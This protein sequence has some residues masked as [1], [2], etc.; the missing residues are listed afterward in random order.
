MKHIKR[1]S[2]DI[3]VPIELGDTILGGRF[4]NKKVVVKKIGKNKKGDITVNDKPLLKYRIVKESISLKDI[5]NY[6]AYLIDDGF[7]VYKKNHLLKKYSVGIFKLN[8]GLP[9]TINNLQILDNDKLEIDATPFIELFKNEIEYIS[10]SYKKDK[11]YYRSQLKPD[12][13]I[14]NGFTGNIIKIVI[15]FK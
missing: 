8:T 7:I 6:L 1:F 3:K 9:E 5:N 2:E 13:I 15:I 4:K 14:K 11:Q 10:I 12:V